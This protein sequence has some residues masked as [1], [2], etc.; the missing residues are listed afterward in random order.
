MRPAEFFAEFLTYVALLAGL[1]ILCILVS[2]LSEPWAYVLACAYYA[3]NYGFIFIPWHGEN[4]RNAE[5]SALYRRCQT[6]YDRPRGAP[7]S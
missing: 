3:V 2:N 5:R 4:R 6:K 1:L 7:K